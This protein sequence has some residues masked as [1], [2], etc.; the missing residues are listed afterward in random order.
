MIIVT[1]GSQNFQ[2]N[3]LLK[4]I[5]ELIDD[6]II[7][8]EVFAQIGVSDYRPRNFEY[9]DFVPQQCFL[10]R[11]KEADLVITH[12]GTGAIIN[13]IKNNRKVIGVPRLS[14]YGE[15]VDDHQLQII[16]EFSELNLI[17]PCYRIEDLDNILLN[18]EDKKYNKYISNTNKIIDS[19]K[20]FIS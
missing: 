8:D 6:G 4:K 5:D 15:H 11:I 18:I 17:E 19:I 14:Q 20:E 12:A 2:F 16:K 10:K 3:R 1:V 9:V 7:K 13:S